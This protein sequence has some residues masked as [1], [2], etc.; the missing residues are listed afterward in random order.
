MKIIATLLYA[1]A[2]LAALPQN[3]YAMHIAEGILPGGW[4]AFWYVM[5]APFVGYAL[6]KI[7]RAGKGVDT[8]G[9]ATANKPLIGMVGAAVFIISCMPIPVPVVG[10][11]SHPAGTA[12]AAIIIG[13][14]Y[15]ILAALAALIL[16]A[17]FL[18]HG[19]IST[20]GANV[21]SMGIVGCL[22]GYA[23]YALLRRV[24]L[25]VFAAALVAGIVGD[26][27]TYAT[28]ALELTLGLGKP[29][30][31]AGLYLSISGA[32]SLTQI[33]LGIVEGLLTGFAVRFVVQRRPDLVARPAHAVPVAA[34]TGGAS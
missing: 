25:S 20:L 7:A 16:Q 34:E 23:A 21:F 14:A 11:C 24:G 29:G 3:A 28:T 33:P 12:L 17:L 10:S 8:G 31:Y 22:A 13:P 26:W 18:S 6:V 1:V 30:S 32:F 27:A 2:L 5:C 15:G 4:A 9:V 19:G